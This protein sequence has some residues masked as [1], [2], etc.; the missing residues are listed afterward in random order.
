M[1]ISNAKIP[2]PYVFFFA[3]TVPWFFFLLLDIFYKPVGQEDPVILFTGLIAFAVPPTCFL[4]GFLLSLKL[5]GYHRLNGMMINT[6]GL[7]ALIFIWVLG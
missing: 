2:L 6:L 1:P 3:G 4:V 5:S 7:A